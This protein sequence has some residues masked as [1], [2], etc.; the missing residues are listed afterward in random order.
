MVSTAAAGNDAD[1]KF[2][3]EHS[4]PNVENIPESFQKN[5]RLFLN[6]LNE[7]SKNKNN[8]IKKGIVIRNYYLNEKYSKFFSDLLKK[9]LY[10]KIN[11]LENK[12]YESEIRKGLSNLYGK[13]NRN[14]IS[15][16]EIEKSLTQILELTQV[17]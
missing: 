6:K 13:L 10:E 7:V 2:Y 4:T 16:Y 3:L 15:C 14:K 8:L 9:E 11:L 17:K 12:K 1:R 5:L